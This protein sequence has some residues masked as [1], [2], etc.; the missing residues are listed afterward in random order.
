MS[1][2]GYLFYFFIV[3]LANVFGLLTGFNITLL[4]LVMA[5]ALL[6]AFALRKTSANRS[7]TRFRDSKKAEMLDNSVTKPANFRHEFIYNDCSTKT[8][9][10]TEL[11]YFVCIIAN[12][13]LRW[14]GLLS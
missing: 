2:L 13:L 14:I 7:G 1:L 5:L 9:L 3:I 10:F 12:L 8:L 4:Y 11:P 6:A